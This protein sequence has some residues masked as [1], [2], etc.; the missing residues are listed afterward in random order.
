MFKRNFSNQF[1][2]VKLYT[3]H[4]WNCK[5]VCSMYFIFFTSFL[6]SLYNNNHS[7]ILTFSWYVFRVN[8]SMYV[9]AFHFTKCSWLN[10]M[11]KIN[12]N[13]Q[14]NWNMQSH[15]SIWC[16][17]TNHMCC[18]LWEPI[19]L[20][21]FFDLPCTTLSFVLRIQC[22][23]KFFYTEKYWINNMY[24]NVVQPIPKK[25]NETVSI[26]YMYVVIKKISIL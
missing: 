21:I 6:L 16:H 12:N 25:M 11:R 7:V 23:N 9:F 18:Q 5:L 22:S 24:L 1:W 15:L 14:M 8:C 20:I 13:S 19:I 2:L 4:M 26:W 17:R 3:T 10:R